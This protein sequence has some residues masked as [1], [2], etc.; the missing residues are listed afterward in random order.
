MAGY[1]KAAHIYYTVVV[2]CVYVNDTISILNKAVVHKVDFL[3][4]SKSIIISM[5]MSTHGC[6]VITTQSSEVTI[7]T[8]ESVSS[9]TY[10]T[11]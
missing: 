7:L 5:H 11:V 1:G 10:V 4:L 9:I 8:L 3:P 2:I 6:Q